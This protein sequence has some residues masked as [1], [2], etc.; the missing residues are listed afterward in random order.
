MTRRPFLYCRFGAVQRYYGDVN[1][2]INS[3][4]MTLF[5]SKKLFS[6]LGVGKIKLESEF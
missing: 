5:E 3:R 4:V 6:F 1:G 2:N